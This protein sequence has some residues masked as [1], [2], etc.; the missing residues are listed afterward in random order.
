MTPRLRIW[1]DAD[2]EQPSTSSIKSSTF[3]RSDCGANTMSS[4][5]SLLSLR[6]LLSSQSFMSFR[7]LISV[8]G[9]RGVEGLVLM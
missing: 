2:I 8:N 6:K 9:G 5:L 4:V 3:L 1:E 7:Q